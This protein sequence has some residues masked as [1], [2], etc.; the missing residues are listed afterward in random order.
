MEQLKYLEIPDSLRKIGN[1][2]ILNVSLKLIPKNVSSS[3]TIYYIGSPNSNLY[4]IGAN[5]FNNCIDPD[6]TGLIITPSIIEINTSAQNPSFG[7]FNN[8]IHLKNIEFGYSNKGI[9]INYIEGSKPILFNE[10]AN[11]Y[12]KLERITIYKSP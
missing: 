7:Y 1:S 3:S 8:A 12:P 10:K 9:K 6:C 2:A 4:S 5:G 11:N